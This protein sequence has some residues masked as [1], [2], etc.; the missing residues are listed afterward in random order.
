MGQ[1]VT[2]NYLLYHASCRVNLRFMQSLM[3]ML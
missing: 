2:V 3:K 1:F